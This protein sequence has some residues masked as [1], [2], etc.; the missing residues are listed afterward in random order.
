MWT[1]GSQSGNEPQEQNLPHSETEKITPDVSIQDG[2]VTKVTHADG[3]IDYIDSKAIGG[4]YATMRRGYFRSPQFI[5]TLTVGIEFSKN[6][7]L[8]RG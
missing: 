7:K 6:L 3:A 2:N 1:T 8:C 4:D 5:G